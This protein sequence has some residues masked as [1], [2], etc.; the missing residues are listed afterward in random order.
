MFLR[1]Q[2]PQDFRRFLSLARQGE[3][4]GPHL[5]SGYEC[6]SRTA[7][8]RRVGSLRSLQPCRNALCQRQP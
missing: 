7:D 5:S 4:A 3:A 6:P 8:R 2:A 1:N